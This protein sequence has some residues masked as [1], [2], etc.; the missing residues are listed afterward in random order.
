VV[1]VQRSGILRALVC[2]AA[3]FIAGGF[4][5]SP[6]PAGALTGATKPT[7]APSSTST[8][9]PIE[10]KAYIVIDADTGA[11]VA[12]KNDRARL[13]PASLTKVLTAVTAAPLLDRAGT[14][15]IS[16]R[17]AGQPSNKVGA[18]AGQ[19]WPVDVAMNVMLMQSANDLAMAVAEQAGGTAEDFQEVMG[20]AALR[21]GM[22]DEPVLHDPAGL[23]DAQSVDG[24]NLVSA[25]D[26]AIASRALVAD[27]WLGPIVAAKRY[28]FTDPAG[29]VHDAANHNKMVLNGGYAGAVGVKTGF[30]KRAGRSLIGAA[31]R[32]GRTM[33]AVVLNVPDT[34][35]WTGRLLDLGFASPVD[36]QAALPHL[37]PVVQLAAADIAP[38]P[39]PKPAPVAASASAAIPA[40]TPTSFAAAAVVATPKG[41]PNLL[42]V[43]VLGGGAIVLFTAGIVRVRRVTS[44]DYRVD[45]RRRARG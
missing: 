17:A 33:I 27:P 4:A 36:A 10:P 34:Y 31:R 13:P 7:T 39:K 19:E 6:A 2:A 12:A 41:G 29:V 40:N 43:V 44:D 24:G 30:T 22:Q 16:P 3:L 45:R 15:T 42:M 26:L 28:Q 23:D 18:L 35:G 38:K 25:R 9:V 14:I 21:L 5:T 1:T 32:D 8:T 37:G 20:K 11:V